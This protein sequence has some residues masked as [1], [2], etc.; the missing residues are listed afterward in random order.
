MVSAFPAVGCVSA[1]TY[2]QDLAEAR[3][4]TRIAQQNAA[5]QGEAFRTAIS[6]IQRALE[7]ESQ[8][9]QAA[10]RS[11]EL[12]ITRLENA[13]KEVAKEAARHDS[14]D[15]PA[16]APG[17]RN[18]LASLRS[19]VQRLR[20]QEEAAR[21]RVRRLEESIQ[22]LS[23]RSKA[24]VPTGTDLDIRNPWSKLHAYPY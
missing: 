2:D 20:E 3:L 14:A 13:Q 11:L 7:A 16:A 24:I 5:A 8:L 6:A 9:H 1:A 18:E 22:Q 23:A 17:A 19:E 12:Q 15:A 10:V 4:Q 21:G